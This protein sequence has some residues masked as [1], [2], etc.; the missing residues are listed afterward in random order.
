MNMCSQV[1]SVFGRATVGTF[2]NA[3]IKVGESMD[4]GG[5]NFMREAQLALAPVLCEYVWPNRQGEGDLVFKAD[6]TIEGT[7][8][9]CASRSSSPAV[10]TWVVLDAGKQCV[11]KSM[12]A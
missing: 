10:E 7:K 9:T 11:K 1:L 2:T 12:S 5:K 3:Q 4:Q 6:A 8:D